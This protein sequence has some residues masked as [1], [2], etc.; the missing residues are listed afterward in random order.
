MSLVVDSNV[1]FA[2]MLRDGATRGL[3][4]EPPMP[5]LSPEWMLSEIRAHV[6]EISRRSGI[7][8]RDLALLL[9]LLCENIEVV[10]EPEY[11]PQ[12]ARARGMT[13]QD[14]GDAPFVAVAL[15]RACQGIWTQNTRHF[16]GTGIDVWST[17]RIL[18]WVRSQG[19]AA[20]RA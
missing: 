3:L 19:A 6:P 2:A 13:P 8:E 12:M 1:I 18:E 15:S 11:A 9:A 20:R 7:G 17:A 4:V 16:E 5:L 14:P 10:P